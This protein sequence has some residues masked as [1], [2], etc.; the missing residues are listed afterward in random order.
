MTAYGLDLEEAVVRLGVWGSK[1]L[2]RPG[3]DASFSLSALALALRGAFDPSKATGRDLLLEIRLGDEPPLV[4]M[5]SEGRVSFPITPP[6][7]PI[8]L[9]TV[10]EVVSELLVGSLDVSAAVASGRARVD[11]SIREAARFFEVFRLPA[12]EPVTGDRWR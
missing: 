7:R 8:V 12:R 5:V 2:G 10:P 3:E 1:S 9:E 6:S 4:V 11:G